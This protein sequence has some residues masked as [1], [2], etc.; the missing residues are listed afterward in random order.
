MELALSL[1]SHITWPIAFLI[2]FIT[3]FFPI[4]SLL[5][6]LIDAC[7]KA[8]KF[9]FGSFKLSSRSS[10][11][12]G[13]D[14]SNNADYLEMLK[15]FDSETIKNEERAIKKQLSKSKCTSKQATDIL[16]SQLANRVVLTHLLFI[17]RSILESQTSILAFLNSDRGRHTIEPLN[18]YFEAYTKTYE[19]Q[20]INDLGIP[21]MTIDQFMAFLIV[22]RL[23]DHNMQGFAITSLGI[24]YLS[25]IVRL[26]QKLPNI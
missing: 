26:G 12:L 5:K 9:E 3:L 24:D 23:I 22:N 2:I 16:I 7:G 21:K 4:K 11:E 19:L 15:A 1:L 20:K 25:F 6:C 13:D 18:K 14:N 10:L 8:D 17:N